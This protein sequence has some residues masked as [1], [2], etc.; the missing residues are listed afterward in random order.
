MSDDITTAR[1]LATHANDIKHLQDDMDAMKADLVAI[2]SS[3][4]DIKGTLS[5]AQ[6]GWRV[7]IFIGSIASGVIGAISGYLTSKGL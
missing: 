4:D 3:L 6:G 5:S 2:R 7:L 1:E